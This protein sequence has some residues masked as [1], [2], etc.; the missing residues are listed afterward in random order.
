MWRLD[1]TTEF[2]E[3]SPREVLAKKLRK[4]A[5]GACSVFIDYSS[6]SRRFCFFASFF[7]FFSFFRS[8][9]LFSSI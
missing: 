7:R 5:G 4:V 9:S 3:S 2:D 1:P 6:R 8:F